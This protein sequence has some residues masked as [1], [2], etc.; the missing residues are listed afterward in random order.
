MV[1]NNRER[2]VY[3]LPPYQ[4]PPVWTVAQSAAFLTR[5]LRGDPGGT[6]ILWEHERRT[7]LLDGQQRLTALGAR[8][9]RA[10]GSENP[11]PELYLDLHAYGHEPDDDVP[12]W[13]PEPRGEWS[14]TVAQLLDWEWS[15]DTFKRADE[16][17]ADLAIEAR[18][19]MEDAEFHIMIAGHW[20]GCS[21]ADAVRLFRTANTGGTPMSAEDIAALLRMA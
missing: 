9:V 7:I 16:V 3:H 6:L 14:P 10:D 19:N 8:V 17:T 12:I 4:R 2:A 15:F 13:H 20:H 21:P 18:T 11:T 1:I 5:L